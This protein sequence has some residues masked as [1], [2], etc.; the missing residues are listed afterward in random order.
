MGKEK[1]EKVLLIISTTRKSPKSIER[2]IEYAREKNAELVCLYV[3]DLELPKSIVKQMTEEGWLG[4]KPSEDFYLALLKEYERWG[5]EKIE[6]IKKEAEKHQI[7]FRA[8]IRRGDFLNQALDFINQE[9]VNYIIVT[10]R[11]RSNL[12][13]FL[14]GS[15]VAELKKQVSVPVE[16]IDE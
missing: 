16:I 13:R 12:S 5:K 15:A 10:R 8:E 9:Q 14:F 7:P 1:R 6:E 11:R 2:A 3:L 4:G